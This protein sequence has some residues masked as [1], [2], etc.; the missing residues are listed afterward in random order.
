MLSGCI[1]KAKKTI[2]WGWGIHLYEKS[3][4]YR[5]IFEMGCPVFVIAK[6]LD[7]SEAEIFRYINGEK[8]PPEAKKKIE[9]AL[10]GFNRYK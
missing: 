9:V 7:T 3:I 6:D 1:W 5:L 10:A 4:I 8:I 2:F